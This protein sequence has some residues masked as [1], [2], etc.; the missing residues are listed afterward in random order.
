M[1]MAHGKRRKSGHAAGWAAVVAG[2]AVAMPIHT[3]DAEGP[4]KPAAA[5]A[6]QQAWAQ[7]DALKGAVDAIAP[8]QIKTGMKGYGLTVFHGTKPEPFAVEVVSVQRDF[9][10]DHSVVWVRC[11]DERMQLSGPVQGMSGSPIYLWGEGEAKELGKGGKLVGAFAFGFAGGKDCFVG[12]QPIGYMRDVGSRVKGE[13][14]KPAV[15]EGNA[16]AEDGP[17]SA[18]GADTLERL[19]ASYH[20]G[21]GLPDQSYVAKAIFGALGGAAKSKASTDAARVASAVPAEIA[22]GGAEIRP[23]MLPMRFSSPAIAAAMKPML[24]PVGISAMAGGAA[25]AGRPP[26]GIDPEAVKFEPG[27]TLTIPL[28]WGSM[29]LCALGTVTDVLPDGRVLAFGH[30]MLGMGSSSFPM[31]TGYVHFVQPSTKISFK[32]GGSAAIRGTI[33]RDEKSAIAGAPLQAYAAAPLTVTVNMPAQKPAVFKYHIV[34]N[35]S[36]TP[37]IVAAVAMESISAVQNIPQDNTVH[38]RGALKFE[39]NRQIDIDSLLVHDEAMGGD[40][41]LM[42]LIPPIAA[43]MQ[44]QHQALLLTEAT[45]DVD[46]TPR[47]QIATMGSA[48]LDRAKCVPGEKIGMTVRLHPFGKTAFDKRLELTV[49]DTT[50]D[51]DYML[52][53]CD[54]ASYLQTIVM[55]KPHLLATTNIEDLVTLVKK[56]MAIKSDGVYAVLFLNEEG[57]VVGHHEM[58]QLPSSRRALLAAPAVTNVAAFTQTVESSTS[59]GLLVTGGQMF[60]LSVRKNP[61]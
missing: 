54:P 42:N 2:F 55:T 12:I 4:A 32:I 51:G 28:A 44:N 52:A 6:K 34:N 45:L 11:P 31:S 20:R 26:D 38:L 56:V 48:R 7:D 36:M 27:S 35:K 18:M 21:E 14:N 43:L 60:T 40:S 22:A 57:V 39:G 3:V 33:L 17:M 37:M 24:D 8:E 19:L 30:S 29:D 1:K 58:P 41:L 25:V 49:P 23:L 50:P 16:R 9:A 13:A 46:V 15:A 5:E 59:T 61:R 10:P 53:V 47:L